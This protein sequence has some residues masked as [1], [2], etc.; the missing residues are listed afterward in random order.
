MPALNV[1]V[2]ILGISGI[3]VRKFIPAL[4]AS[5]CARLVAAGTGRPDTPAA[6]AL[7]ERGAALATYDGLLARD[8]LDLVYISLPNHL[9]EE[10]TLRAL[11]AGKHVLCEKPLAPSLDAVERMLTAAREHRRLL[12][13]A[14]M[15]IHHPQHAAVRAEIEAG[16]IGAVRQ[17]RA[18]FAFTLRKPGDFR[19]DPLRAGGACNDL[20]NYMVGAANLFLPGSL[21][22]AAGYMTRR[23]GI[24]VAASGIARTEAGHTL[25]FTVGFEQHYE[26]WYELIGDAGILRLDRAFTTPPETANV[27]SARLAGGDRSIALPAADHFAEMIR[28]VCGRIAAGRTDTEAESILRVHRQIDLIRRSLQHRE[29]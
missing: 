3:A 5:G 11:A 10:W 24:D 27:L 1:A 14:V 18:A 26:C 9:H 7:A 17:V 20:L 22:D 13:E 19:L 16:R 23:G 8:D 6:R 28:H 12:H 2:G 4:D 25:Q 21:V 29:A 15:F